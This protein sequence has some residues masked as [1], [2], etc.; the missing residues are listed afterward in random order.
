MITYNNEADGTITSDILQTFVGKFVK[1]EILPPFNPAHNIKMAATLPDGKRKYQRSQ[2]E[3][4][5]CRN[6]ILDVSNRRI[7]V[8]YCVAIK[9]SVETT[10][11]LR[12]Q[13]SLYAETLNRP[14]TDHDLCSI[15]MIRIGERNYNNP[16]FNI[17]DQE[18]WGDTLREHIF[19]L[20]I[21]NATVIEKASELPPEMLTLAPRIVESYYGKH[22]IHESLP[23]MLDE[24]A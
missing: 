18:V 14:L 4:E 13:L 23:E 5:I 17:P 16:E 22:K 1:I 10:K 3:I 20:R 24:Y 21:V 15:I 19:A 9:S 2:D 8:G 7:K 11:V 12:E 6:H